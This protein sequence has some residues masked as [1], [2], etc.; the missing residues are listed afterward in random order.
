V[1]GNISSEHSVFEYMADQTQAFSF[2]FESFKITD[3]R[4]LHEDTDYAS[5]TLLVNS[6]AGS[7]TPK[8]LTKKMGDLNNGTFPVN[9]SFPVVS[10]GSSDRVALNYLI[11]NSG[12][13]NPSQIVS[14]LESAGGKLAVGAMTGL[15]ASIGSVIPG[16]G[17]A[18]GA[19]AGWLAGEI[20]GLINANCDGTVAAEQN[21]FTLNDLLA[22][23]AKGRFTQTTKHP[24]TDSPH[25]CGG[26]SM[27]FVTW[28]IDRA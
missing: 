2:V 12:H 27:Y 14:T 10:I 18:L 6:A 22:K 28:H 17:T 13:K 5:F 7:G 21:T 3:T 20:T 24:G 26:N 15:G 11:V 4:S 19:L 1:T 8:T 16:F 9:L 23:T 25:G